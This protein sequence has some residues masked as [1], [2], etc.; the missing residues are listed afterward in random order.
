MKIKDKTFVSIDY[1]LKLDS[2]ETVDKSEPGKPFSFV[3]GSGQVI[4]GLEKGLKGLEKGETTTITVEAADG[5]GEQRPDLM[6]EIPR[7]QFPANID[8]KPGMA[9]EA[10]SPQGPMR[11]TISQVNEDMVVA[12]FNHPLAGERLHFDIT[13]SEVREPRPEDMAALAGSGCDC[14]TDPSSCGSCGGGCC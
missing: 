2:G 5:Y 6:R 13:V 7:S 9:F 14:S 11:F 4:P 8:L 1:T 10:E 3:V 12:D